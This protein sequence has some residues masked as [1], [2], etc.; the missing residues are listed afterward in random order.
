MPPDLAAPGADAALA[1]RASAEAARRRQ[2]VGGPPDEDAA[3]DAEQPQESGRGA[4][5]ADALVRLVQGDA[6][7]GAGQVV[8]HVDDETLRDED[9]IH[10]CCE[11]ADGPAVPPETARRLSCDASVIV[12]R[13][14]EG[15]PF[16]VG[17]RTRSIP[18]AL[19]RALER[20]D[21]ECRFPGCHSPHRLHAHHIVH[22]ARGGATDLENL[23]LICPFHHRLVHEGG[24][25]LVRNGDEFTFLRPDGRPISTV[26]PPTAGAS[27]GLVAANERAGTDIDADSCVSLWTGEPLDLHWTVMT[28]CDREGRADRADRAA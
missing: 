12:M 22:W 9:C 6:R 17:R 15:K 4:R 23:V 26:S 3:E 5:A 28:L 8:I 1:R 18:P 2:G 10:D 11:V 14:R 13:E 19:R 21:R 7:P 27:E 20:R 25:G 16:D 24:F